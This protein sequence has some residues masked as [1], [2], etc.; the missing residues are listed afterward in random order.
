V[1]A[2]KNDIISQKTVDKSLIS[3]IIYTENKF[4]GKTMKT[5]L[6]QIIKSAIA[7]RGYTQDAVA[8]KSGWKNQSSLAT[9]INRDNPSVDTM[10]RILDALEYEIVIVD[11]NSGTKWTVTASGEDGE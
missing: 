4:G 3:D 2:Y 10:F 8:K 1:Q 5:N 9:A 11:K 6:K 7:H